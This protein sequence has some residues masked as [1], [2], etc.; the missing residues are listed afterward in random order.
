MLTHGN[1]TIFVHISINSFSDKFGI[2]S[3]KLVYVDP[4]LDIGSNGYNLQII[5][6]HVIGW[7]Q[8]VVTCH[9][10]FDIDMR[11]KNVLKFVQIYQNM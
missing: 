7:V 3:R 9:A 2:W 4:F 1:D 8:L 5:A 11:V 10:L 6:F